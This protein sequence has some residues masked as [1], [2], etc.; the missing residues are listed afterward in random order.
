MRREIVNTQSKWQEDL[1]HDYFDLSS[2][3][4]VVLLPGNGYTVEGPIF[5]YLIGEI[6][7]LG[8]DVLGI[9]YGF[10]LAQVKPELDEYDG[11]IDEIID[12]IEHT[13]NYKSYIFIGKSLGTRYLKTLQDKYGG[14]CIYITPTDIM[15]GYGIAREPVFIYGDKDKYLSDKRR[16]ELSKYKHHVVK[17]GGHS[18][19]CDDLEESLKELLDVVYFVKG[20]IQ[21]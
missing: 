5:Y 17:G 19:L 14:K 21:I 12:A 18:L 9:N 2:D 16:L 13:K 1:K 7:K 4:L 20:C 8:Y 15:L 6:F 3:T 11:L 10:Q